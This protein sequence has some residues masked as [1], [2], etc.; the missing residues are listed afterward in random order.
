MKK[1]VWIIGIMFLVSLGISGTAFAKHHHHRKNDK[2]NKVRCLVK[3]AEQMVK[4]EDACKELKGTVVPD[5][6]SKD[7][8]AKT[9]PENK[10]KVKPIQG[11]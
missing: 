4:S 10:L 9:A 3:G 5:K 2:E 6:A 1:R 7:A 8:A 11:E